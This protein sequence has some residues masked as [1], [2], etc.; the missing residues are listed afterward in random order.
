MHSAG[1]ASGD[2]SR[3]EA[4]R[5]TAQ[6]AAAA[7]QQL[8]ETEAAWVASKMARTDYAADASSR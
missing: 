2:G 3:T 5:V 1:D 7:R 8:D 4:M 6:L